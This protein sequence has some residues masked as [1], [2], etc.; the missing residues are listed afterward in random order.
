MKDKIERYIIIREGRNWYKMDLLDIIA[1]T[2]NISKSKVK[3][4]WFQDGIDIYI[5]KV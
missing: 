4:L 3:Q 1:K 5:E 2:R